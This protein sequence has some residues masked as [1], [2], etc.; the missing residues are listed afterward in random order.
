MSKRQSGKARRSSTSASQ[1]SK[2]V[3]SVPVSAPAPAAGLWW[4]TA[5]VFA[6]ALLWR[7]VHLWQLR[8]APFFPL[9]M[10]DA[11]GYDEWAQRIAGGDWLGHDVFYQ[12]PLYPYVLAVLYRVVGHDLTIVRLFQI[13]LGS[14]ACALMT[15]TTGRLFNPRAGLIA[16]LLLALCGPAIFFDGLLQKAALDL[17]F[18]C[19]LLLA[20]AFLVERI[21][22]ARALVAG[23]LLGCLA[24]TRENALVLLPALLAWM[25]W[26]VRSHALTPVVALLLGLAIILAPVALRNFIVGGEL[27]LTTAQAGPNFYIGNHEGASG[28]YEPLRKARGNAAYERQDA[29]DLA[30]QAVGRRLTAGEVSSYWWRRGFDW[31]ATHPIDWLRLTAKKLLLVWNAEEVTD[32]E[33]LYSHGEWS[34]P[35]R[36]GA[37]ILHIGVLAP[38]GLLGIWLT[39]SRWR[40]LWV[41]YAMAAIYALSVALFFVLARYR[42][43]LVP[44]L[45][46]FAGAGLAELPAWWRSSALGRGRERWLA[47]AVVIVAAIVC[48]WPI[49]STSAMRAVTHY[50]IGYELQTRG[51]LDEAAAEYRAS[52]ALYPDYALTHSNLGVLLAAQGQ[53]DEARAQYREALR[54]EPTLTEA[55]VNLGIELAEGGETANAIDLF[56]RAIAR[57]PQNVNAHYNLGLA[58][59]A[60]DQLDEA[61]REFEQTLALD[62]SHAAAHNNLGILAASQGRLDEGILHFRAA[63]RLHPDYPAAAANLQRAQAEASARH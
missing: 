51:Q 50:N 55:Q 58:L 35:L 20:V 4:M 54:I 12:A 14:A 40:E 45:I 16:G 2:S 57:D 59:T 37:S 18:L 32:T 39:R 22:F 1:P 24:L 61:R 25:I 33:D 56:R 36:I 62:P 46:L 41:F 13:L 28:L 23:V 52:L 48:N 47:L 27:H 11:L 10:G 15:L 19:A 31:I 34:L 29:I 9:L 43:P 21:T 42:Y 17:F 6:F 30:Q 26:R 49:V 44:F 7:A 8:R 60:T 5:G 53:H 63:L 38:L 3:A